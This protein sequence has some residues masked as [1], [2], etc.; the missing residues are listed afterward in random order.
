MRYMVTIQIKWEGREETKNERL[1]VVKD[2]LSALPCLKTTP[3]ESNYISYIC[4]N[5]VVNVSAVFGV[6]DIEI[7]GV[8]NT[9]FD[10]AIIMASK[11]KKY[12]E[13]RIN[14]KKWSEGSPETMVYANMYEVEVK[15]G[16]ES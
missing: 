7:T 10:Y 15:C 6:I 4:G 2:V 13:D 12:I 3:V 14:E 1:G 8:D 9:I 11:I 5:M 16:C